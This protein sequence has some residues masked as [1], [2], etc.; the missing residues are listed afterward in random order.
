MQFANDRLRGLLAEWRGEADALQTPLTVGGLL[1]YHRARLKGAPVSVD[2]KDKSAWAY[3]HILAHWSVQREAKEITGKAVMDWTADLSARYSR[4]TIRGILV[5]LRAALTAAHRDGRLSR[6]P[7]FPIPT[8]PRRDVRIPDAELSALWARVDLQNPM[9]LL[10]A[11][12]AGTGVREKDALA[13]TWEAFDWKARTVTFWVSKAREEKP[14]KLTVPMFSPLPERLFAVRQETGRL[15]SGK[16]RRGGRLRH[17]I[18]SLLGHWGP[19]EPNQEG[20]RIVMRRKFIYGP[21]YG[22]HAFRHT[23]T[24]RLVDAGATIHETMEA[25]GHESIKTTMGYYHKRDASP[26][27]KMRDRLDAA[28]SPKQ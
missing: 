5:V 19:K 21:A 11:I 17:T 14:K 22:P 13:L 16:W 28:L 20:T 6:L 8:M 15:F 2:H 1:D 24:S 25:M 26:A 18:S 12:V 3:G 27:L 7:D 10:L 4:G 23:L 9:H